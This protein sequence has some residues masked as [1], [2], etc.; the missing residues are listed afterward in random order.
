MYEPDIL[1]EISGKITEYI[2]QAYNAGYDAC[3]KNYNE[4]IKD[5]LFTKEQ[6]I[7]ACEKSFKEG[8]DK[9]YEFGF[10]DGKQD[11]Y[12][13]Y[14]GKID[15]ACEEARFNGFDEGYEKGLRERN[16][17]EKTFDEGLEA[18]FEAI[19]LICNND[20]TDRVL[21]RRIMDAFNTVSAEIILKEFTIKEIVDKVDFY[22]TNKY[23]RDPERKERIARRR[24]ENR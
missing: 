8:S 21:D 4:K 6:M 2:D 19:K 9:G 13:F 10:E 5:G 7:E 24:H 20:H 16:K 23:L 17:D 11:S 12:D 14:M 18:A 3:A 1:S 15:S 22:R